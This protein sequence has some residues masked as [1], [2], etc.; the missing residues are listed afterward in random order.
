MQN[1][2]L[3]IEIPFAKVPRRG[4]TFTYRFVYDTPTFEL[5]TFRPSP[6][7][8]LQGMVT[9]SSDTTGW[10]VPDPTFWIVNSV[11]T[12]HACSSPPGNYQVR[13]MWT[14]TDPEG[15]K[16]PLL[17]RSNSS[18]CSVDANGGTIASQLTGYT[19]DGT[20]IFVDVTSNP[21][22]PRIVL[23]DGTQV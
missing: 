23:K 19:L 16:H 21:L 3:H 15:A 9:L 7:S 10:R 4:S 14:V 20:G 6:T 12:D 5:N 1:G 8:P 13:S 18:P 2:N 22:T 11:L 17:L